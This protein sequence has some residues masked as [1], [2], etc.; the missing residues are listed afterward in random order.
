MGSRLT[1]SIQEDLLD[2]I[3]ALRNLGHNVITNHEI[4]RETSI[5]ILSN[6]DE[7]WEELRSIEWIPYEDNKYIITINASKL[8]LTEILEIVDSVSIKA[9]LYEKDERKIKVSVEEQLSNI[10]NLLI[11][12]GYNVIPSYKVD[13]DVA[14]M[15]FSGVDEDWETISTY[16]MRQ[17]GDTKQVLTLNA[18]NMNQDEILETINRL[19]EKTQ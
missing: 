13:N 3:D 18:S 16:Q 5:F 14:A 2:I 8:T 11:E 6:V 15:I 17:Y 19:C 9:S 4:N 10:K 7:E 12:N 1:I